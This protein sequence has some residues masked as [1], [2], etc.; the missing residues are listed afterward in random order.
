MEQSTTKVY[1]RG[2]DGAY[3]MGSGAEW[4]FTTDRKKATV[5]DYLG[6]RIAEQVDGLRRE[7][8][9]SLKVELID[10]R[11]VHESCDECEQLISPTKA[12]FN[13]EKF[14]CSDCRD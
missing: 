3:L 14:L 12:F 1:I 10:P 7:H 5:F 11:E 4:E 6:D 8:G 13:G 2:Q 9:I